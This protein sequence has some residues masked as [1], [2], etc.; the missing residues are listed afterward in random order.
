MKANI[1]FLLRLAAALLLVVAVSGCTEKTSTDAKADGGNAVP[2]QGNGYGN[3]IE[4]GGPGAGNGVAQG[5]DINTAEAGSGTNAAEPGRGADSNAQDARLTIASWN[6]QV[7]GVK[8]ASDSALMDYYASKI[9]DYDIVIVQEIRDSSGEAFRMLCAKLPEHKCA[10]SSRAGSTSSKEQYGVIYRKA[11]LAGTRDYN[12]EM[13]GSFERP[14]FEVD[15]TYAGWSFRLITI[16]VDPDE[17]P[18]EMA[19]LDS[20]FRD[21]NEDTILLGDLNADCKYYD[22]NSEQDFNA[23]AWAVPDAE[24]TTVA[25]TDCAYDRIILNKGAEDNF[26]KHGVMS[27]V[28]EGQSDHYLVWGE[29]RAG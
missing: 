29:F 20:L 2:T 19:M 17:A 22:R 18:E 27:D 13:R 11:A 26:E 12:P 4:D 6:L 23:W 25:K 7:F 21:S 5:K 3:G 24:D 15:F 1:S 10:E 28:K 14:P 8:K 16:H 9:R